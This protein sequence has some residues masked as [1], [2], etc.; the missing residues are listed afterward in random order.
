MYKVHDPGRTPFPHLEQGL[1][2]R[3]GRVG[4]ISIHNRPASAPHSN[5]MARPCHSIHNQNE[6]S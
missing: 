5:R 3:R 6:L 1:Q 2:V 4:R